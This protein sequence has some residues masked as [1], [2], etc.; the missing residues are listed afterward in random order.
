MKKVCIAILTLSIILGCSKEPSNGNEDETKSINVKLVEKNGV[1]I[2]TCND[3]NVGDWIDFEEK[4]YYVVGNNDKSIAL[5]LISDGGNG[6][7]CVCTSKVTNMSGWFQGVDYQIESIFDWDTSNVTDMSYLFADAQIRPSLAGWDVSSVTDMSYMFQNTD[8]QLNDYMANWDTS[9]VTTMKG[10][11]E[12]A[13]RFNGS[14]ENWNT[15]NVTDMSFMFHNANQFN[16]DLGN[17]NT[18]SVTN[19]E[20]MFDIDFALTGDFNY[21][22]ENWNTSSVTNMKRMFHGQSSFNQDLNKWDVSKVETMQLMFGRCFG[23]NQHILDWNTANVTD[24]DGF[25]YDTRSWIKTKPFFDNCDASYPNS[26]GTYPN[27]YEANYNGLFAGTIKQGNIYIFPDDAESYAGFAQTRAELY[28]MAFYRGGK[29]SFKAKTLNEVNVKVYF[30]FEKNVYP[31][32][33]PSFDTDFIEVSSQDLTEY[34][35]EIPVQSLDNTFSSTLMYFMDK[36]SRL[37]MNEFK[38]EVY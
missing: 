15:S 9:N 27:I 28:P 26:N 4:Q 11:F 34:S 24:C 25:A 6:N 22:L 21:S 14:V 13:E 12:G 38:I 31:D 7:T 29:I 33:E 10:M 2:V 23:F 37:E 35:I 1:N 3:A 18:G 30:R 17:W 5:E 8:Y 16:R 32:T 36:G 19:M 20:S